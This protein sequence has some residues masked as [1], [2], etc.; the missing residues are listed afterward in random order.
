MIADAAGSSAI[1]RDH[2]RPEVAG[3]VA[4]E[5]PGRQY[6]RHAQS[7]ARSGR[8]EIHL[9]CHFERPRNGLRRPADAFYGG[10][11]SQNSVE[12]GGRIVRLVGGPFYSVRIFFDQQALERPQA[13]PQNQYRLANMK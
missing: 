5:A 8:R 11:V 7:C 12:D 1:G 3:H 10:G 4:R 6:Q 2:P 9:T 13:V